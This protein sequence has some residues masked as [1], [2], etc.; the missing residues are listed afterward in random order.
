MKNRNAGPPVQAF[1]YKTW[2]T[3]HCLYGT[4]TH[5]IMCKGTLGISFLLCVSSTLLDSARTGFKYMRACCFENVLKLHVYMSVQTWVHGS[6]LPSL[7][8][9]VLPGQSLNP[10]SLDLH[11]TPLG[12]AQPYS[13]FKHRIQEPH[14]L[15]NPDHTTRHR[16]EVPRH[17][18][19]P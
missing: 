11:I 10:T 7:L 12:G 14:S 1:C 16:P 4:F 19:G 5:R 8:D 17:A 3:F 15:S 13:T 18:H 9:K 6:V 2:L